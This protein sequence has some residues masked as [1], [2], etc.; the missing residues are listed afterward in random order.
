[1]RYLSHYAKESPLV[2]DRIGDLLIDLLQSVERD[3]DKAAV[4]AC[5]EV[6]R[7]PGKM[8]EL[9]LVQLSRRPD[10]WE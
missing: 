6:Y 2:L 1:M 9:Q 7:D 3:Q 4:R 5:L 8:H 10:R